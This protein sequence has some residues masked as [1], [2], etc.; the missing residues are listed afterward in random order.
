MMS[1]LFSQQYIS[2]F[3]YI[4]G[5]LPTE[6]GFLTKLEEL[7]INNNRLTGIIPDE[8]TSLDISAFDYSFNELIS[9][10]NNIYIYI[11]I[12]ILINKNMKYK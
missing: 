12:L 11:Y 9:I 2:S 4:L 6:I 10:K 8:I 7:L 3:L 5:S 1:L